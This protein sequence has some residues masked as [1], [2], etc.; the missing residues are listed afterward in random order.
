MLGVANSCVKWVMVTIVSD[1][2]T[3][4]W[5]ALAVDRFV[6]DRAAG[7]VRVK[8][9]I[10]EASALADARYLAHAMTMK[11][12]LAGVRC[13]GAKVVVRADTLIDRAAAMAI[14]GAHIE[15]LGGRVYIGPD[16]GFTDA[17]LSAL[18]TTTRYIDSPEVA[19]RMARATALGVRDCLAAALGV[20]RLSDKIIGVQ[21]LG[22]VGS[23]LVKLLVEEGARVSGC[24]LDGERERAANIGIEKWEQLIDAPLDALSPCALGGAIDAA[25]VE[26]LKCRALVGAANHLLASPEQE[27]AARLHARGI[28]HLPDF[29]A[30]AGAMVWWAAEVLEGKSPVEA[31]SAVHNIG[32]TAREVLAK[33]REKN[34]SP[35]E[36]ARALAEERLQA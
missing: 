35:L 6:A 30:N 5:A 33:S 17:D 26:R 18:A 29:L 36:V 19:G 28:I 8:R 27:L 20:E 16:L 2:K 11:S 12:A 7:G 34:V 21:G 24:D 15:S 25:I 1:E 10:D 13:G 3:G 32:V 31:E 14:L 23:E 22:H 9:Y 4:L